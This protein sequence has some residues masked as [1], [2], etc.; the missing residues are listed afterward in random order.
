MGTWM[1]EI[2]LHSMAVPIILNNFS[3]EKCHLCEIEI[4]FLLV[5]HFSPS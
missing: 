1:T 4:D 5:F 2:L 3:V